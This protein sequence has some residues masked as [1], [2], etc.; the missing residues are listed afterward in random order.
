MKNE[1]KH[2]QTPWEVRKASAGHSA[3][4]GEHYF[5]Y[6][7]EPLNVM[8]ERTTGEESKDA[9]FIVRAVNSHE[10]LL[11][12]CRESLILFKHLGKLP[13]DFLAVELLE[14]AIA[15]AEGK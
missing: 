8:V 12:A 15:K 1:M 13:A 6:I 7:L 5:D 2:T 11:E 9:A 10:E 4:T 14:K 3:I